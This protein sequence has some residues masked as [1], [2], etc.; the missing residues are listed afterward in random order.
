MWWLD[1]GSLVSDSRQG[2]FCTD[3]FDRKGILTLKDYLKERWMV[4]THIGKASQYYRLWIYSSEELKKFLRIILPYIPVANTLPKVILIYKDPNLQQRWT[5]E[6]CQF[7]KFPRQIVE[8]C[9]T[10]KKKKWRMF[11][12]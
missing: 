5:S 7:T 2:V 4:K 3:G 9:L 12:R 1:D 6:I 8:K 11:R 10:E